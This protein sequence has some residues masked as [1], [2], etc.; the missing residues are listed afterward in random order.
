[1]YIRRKIETRLQENLDRPEIIALVGARQAGKTTLLKRLKD[2]L[3]QKKESTVFINLENTRYLNLLNETPENLFKLTG[4]LPDKRLYVFIDEI[5]YLANPSN[6]LKYIYDE[7]GSKIK[8]IVSGSSAFY[9]DRKFTDSLAGRKRLFELKVLDFKEFLLFRDSGELLRY[10]PGNQLLQKR[11]IPVIA[12]DKLNNLLDEFIKFGA[13]PGVVLE[14]R[15]REKR[16]LLEE[17]LNSYLAKDIE[18]MGIKKK[19]KFYD[20]LRILGMQAGSLTNISELANTLKLSVTAVENYLY[21][22]EKSFQVKRIRPFYSNLRKELTKMPKLY[23]MDLGIRNIVLDNFTWMESRM[24]K[25]T[26]FENLVFKLLDDRDD[27]SRLNFWRTQDQKEVDFIIDRRAA[28]EVKYNGDK[29]NAARYRLFR[30]SYPDI[31]L[32]VV[33]ALNP[34]PNHLTPFDL[35]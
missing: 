25:G 3:D 13:F 26:V 16:Y 4:N 20:L 12:A 27:V 23:F 15:D 18:I 6:F 33:C 7:Y 30:E 29:Y 21:I 8:L 35:I 14:K 31:P 9:I 2:T 10:F 24:D 28:I 1:M 22:L 34:T 17:L 11:E 32:S 5:Q 19:E